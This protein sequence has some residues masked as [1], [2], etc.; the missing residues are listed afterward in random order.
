M[1]ADIHDGPEQP[2]QS[3]AGY[4][5]ARPQRRQIDEILLRRTAGPYIWGQK[6][7]SGRLASAAGV[8]Q[9][10]DPPAGQ[11]GE[12]CGPENST[13]FSLRYTA[14]HRTESSCQDTPRPI[15][16]SPSDMFRHRSALCKNRSKYRSTDIDVRIS[17]LL[18]RGAM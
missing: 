13:H 2:L 8:A 16:L 17:R 12:S 10:P 15:W 7:R 5:D 4:I 9:I 1:R 18:D 14:L 3:E 11:V 6:R